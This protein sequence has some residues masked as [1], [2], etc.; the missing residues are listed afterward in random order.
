MEGLAETEE[1]AR[2][3][4]ARMVTGIPLGRLGISDD[5]GFYAQTPEIFDCYLPSSA[6]TARG[7][8]PSRTFPKKGLFGN[9]LEPRS[10]KTT[11]RGRSADALQKSFSGKSAVLA[12]SPTK[13]R[14]AK[15]EPNGFKIFLS[16]D[17]K[18][19]KKLNFKEFK[20]FEGRAYNH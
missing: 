2:Q 10:P 11:A 9:L 17:V 14:N 5:V 13:I 15:P 18:Y 20:N 6:W 4:K 3:F 19:H 16:F 1:Q 12:G 8:L 7:A